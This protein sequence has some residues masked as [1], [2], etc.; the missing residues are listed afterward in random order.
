MNKQPQMQLFERD[1]YL[2]ALHTLLRDAYDLAIECQ[3][4]YMSGEL[5]LWL[6]RAGDRDAPHVDAAEPF[7]MQLAGRFSEAAAHWRALGCPYEAAQALADSGDETA[8]RQAFT[9]FQ[10]LGAYPAAAAV[11]RRLRELG[12]Q[13]VP[14]GPRPATRA[15]PA[16]L[17]AR[18]IEILRLPPARRSLPQ[19]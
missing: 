11:S 15:N 7:S 18:E 10:R 1:S 13:S 16:R 17:T 8:L 5:A 3:D 12:A 6:R 9:E 19:G 4:R 2:D 14:R